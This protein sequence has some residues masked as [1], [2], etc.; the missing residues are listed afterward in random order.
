MD[1]STSNIDNKT[2]TDILQHLKHVQV[3]D[4][5]TVIHITHNRDNVNFADRVLTIRDKQLVYRH[6]TGASK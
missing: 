2:E 3:R 1:E 5:K 6:Q 4:K